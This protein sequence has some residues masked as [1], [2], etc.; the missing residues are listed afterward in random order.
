MQNYN[1][2]LSEVREIILDKD[3]DSIVYSNTI[4]EYPVSDFIDFDWKSILNNAPL[5]TSNQTFNELKLVSRNTLNRSSE[6]EKLLLKIDNDPNAILYDILNQNNLEIP[7]DYINFFYDVVKP[8]LFNI[9]YFYN[10]PRPYQ[11][12][13]VYNIPISIIETSTHDTPAYPSGHTTLT[14]LTSNIL[15]DIYPKLRSQF[16]SAIGLTG[17]ARIKQ[18][19]HF[20]SDNKAAIIFANV[21]YDKLKSKIRPLFQQ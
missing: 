11:L 9:K 16:I 15:S 12:A 10:R 7:N 4:I 19:V 17:M 8:V 14:A 13:R 6:D 18:G 1:K 21:L 20:P 3:I 5:N 2:I